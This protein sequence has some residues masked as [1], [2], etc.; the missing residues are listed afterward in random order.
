MG[1]DWGVRIS[2]QYCVPVKL[3]DDVSLWYMLKRLAEFEPGYAKRAHD[4]MST[5]DPV[6]K[7]L[8]ARSMQSVIV[9]RDTAEYDEEEVDKEVQNPTPLEA[10]FRYNQRINGEFS[11]GAEF[12]L[13]YNFSEL[14]SDAFEYAAS[15]LLGD[16]HGI[17]LCFERGGAHGEADS[18][19]KERAMF[20][21]YKA[22]R[23]EPKGEIVVT[24][25]GVN[26]PWGVYSMSVPPAPPGIAQLMQ[27]LMSAFGMQAD[28]EV[29]WRVITT[30]DGG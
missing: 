4:A 6:G 11:Q 21:T 9:L 15:K 2:L 29:A 14:L 10:R 16:G 25:G 1:F 30:A 19:A 17:T 7:A 24:R 28:G 8:L 20:I 23:I 26:V 3:S 22:L 13:E 27:K 5:G 12:D 18:T